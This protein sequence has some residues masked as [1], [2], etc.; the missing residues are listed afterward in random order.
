LAAAARSARRSCL[1][2]RWRREPRRAGADAEPR[3]VRKPAAGEAVAATG[4][5][6][7]LAIRAVHLAGSDKHL[8]CGVG[9]RVAPA[10]GPARVAVTG[11]VGVR[12]DLPVSGP[13]PLCAGRM[14]ASA[15]ILPVCR[16]VRLWSPSERAGTGSA[17]RLRWKSVLRPGDQA[18]HDRGGNLQPRLGETSQRLGWSASGAATCTPSCPTPW[19]CGSPTQVI[20]TP[21]DAMNANDGSH[22]RAAA[23]PASPAP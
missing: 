6:G 4:V 8:G 7:R 5:A 21:A 22:L 1:R 15:G 10:A 12:P 23:R 14:P 16:E 19:S 18:Q 11:R 20:P 9:H 3:Q 17:A 2:S 13:V